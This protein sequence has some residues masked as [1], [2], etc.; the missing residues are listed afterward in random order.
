METEVEKSHIPIL[1]S[2]V[3]IQVLGDDLDSILEIVD[4]YTQALP[5]H[6]KELETAFWIGNREQVERY[7]HRIKGGAANLGGQRLSLIAGEIEDAARDGAGDVCRENVPRLRG[8]LDRLLL[9]LEKE[10]WEP[11]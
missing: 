4:S 11:S 1:D 9:A 7:A 8:E 2:D 10:T 3:L 6:V 5:E